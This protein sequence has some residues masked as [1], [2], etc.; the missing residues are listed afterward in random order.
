MLDT[1]HPWTCLQ[2]MNSVDVTHP[3]ELSASLNSTVLVKHKR[4]RIDD[5][6]EWHNTDTVL[7]LPV[8]QDMILCDLKLI[9]SKF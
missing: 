5:V 3:C 6:L 1:S 8:H 4:T 2:H 7:L 9:G